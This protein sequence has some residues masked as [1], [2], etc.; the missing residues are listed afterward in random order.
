MQQ[1]VSLT[2]IIEAIDTV[3][4]GALVVATQHEEIC[5][6][7]DFIR[8]EE[9]DALQTLLATVDVVAANRSKI[10]ATVQ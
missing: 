3:N 9:D 5:W 2:F 7:F 8:K 10:S 6:I 4:T 1:S